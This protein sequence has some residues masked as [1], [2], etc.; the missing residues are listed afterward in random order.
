[1]YVD[2]LLVISVICLLVNH[3]SVLPLGMR[4]VPVSGAIIIVI[5]RIDDYYW[6][7]TIELAITR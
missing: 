2:S 1:M 5:A 4:I 3:Y 7:F 6:M